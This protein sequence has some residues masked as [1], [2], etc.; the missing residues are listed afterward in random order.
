MNK[1]TKHLEEVNRLTFQHKLWLLLSGVVATIIVVFFIDRNI[2]QNSNAFW[3]IIGLGA[4]ITVVWWYWTMKIVHRLISH[5]R[6]ESE[7]LHDLVK[8]I[9]E[10]RE[11]VKN[12]PK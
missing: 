1:I 2:I 3:I 6:E 12:L 9:R 5:R 4:A 10:I 7:I 11:D 8:C